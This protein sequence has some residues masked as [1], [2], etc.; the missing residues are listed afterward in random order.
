VKTGK[1]DFLPSLFRIDEKFCLAFMN[2]LIDYI[3]PV[4]RSLPAFKG[5][6]RFGNFLFHSVLDRLEPVEVVVNKA[7]KFYLPNSVENLGKEIIVKGEYERETVNAIVAHLKPASKP[8][9]FDIGANIGA[10]SVPVKKKLPSVN[11]HAF[12]AS[13]ATFHYLQKNFEANG[14]TNETVVNKLIYSSCGKELNFFDSVQYGKSSLAPTYADKAIKVSSIS[15]DA[16]C[17]KNKIQ[18][19]DV[20]KIDVQGFELDVLKGMTAL[21]KDRKIAAIC[22]EFEDWAEAA[23]GYKVAAAQEYLLANGYSLFDERG[24]KL[25]DVLQQGSVMLWAMPAGE[26]I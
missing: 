25:E 26:T 12:E 10:I 2:I 24:R 16:Y 17:L 7:L 5:K 18:K 21:L 19:I 6:F 20:V 14:L 4:Y 1:I 11:I 13:P 9:F 22:F 3:L 15:I 8:V 23:A